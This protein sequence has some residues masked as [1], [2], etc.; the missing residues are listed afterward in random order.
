MGKELKPVN[1]LGEF[2]DAVGKLREHWGLP[3]HKELWFRG[4]AKD[5]EKTRLRPELYR[6][7]DDAS[8]LKPISK[9]LDIENDL[10]EDFKRN[11]VE[12][13]KEADDK[14]DWDSYFLMQHHEGPTRLLDWSD[15]ALIALHFALRDKKCDDEDAYVYV[16]EAYRLSQKLNKLPG[17][18]IAIKEWE[19]YVKN[20]PAEELD[21]NAWD[22]L[23]LPNFNEDR[24]E[25]DVPPTPLVF[26]MAHITRRIAAQ[27]S[28]FILFGQDPNWLANEFAQEDSLIEAISIPHEH[29]SKLR[30]ELRDCGITESVIYPDLDGIGREMKQLW[31][32]R[33]VAREE[34][35]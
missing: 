15:G 11:A 6:P 20:H 21:T 33:R 7:A 24:L 16:L 5:Y 9:L 3:R 4:E 28:R 14:W 18:K 1:S 23:Y 17:I 19:K 10:H 27:R 35:A 25:A 34:N 32:D 2:I 8:T 22:D 29:K 30:Q 13:E 12:Y 31:E 26:D